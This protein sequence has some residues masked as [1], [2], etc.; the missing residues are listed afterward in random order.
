MGKKSRRQ[1]EAGGGARPHCLLSVR[2]GFFHAPTDQLVLRG[3]KEVLHYLTTEGFGESR[4]APADSLSGLCFVQPCTM[5]A[6]GETRVL[7]G[8]GDRATCGSTKNRLRLGEQIA[9]SAWGRALSIVRVLQPL[10][11]HYEWAAFTQQG[12]FSAIKRLL[13]E[14]VVYYCITHNRAPA[15]AQV[16]PRS[17]TMHMG[18]KEVFARLDLEMTRMKGKVSVVSPTLDA[19]RLDELQRERAAALSAEPAGW[20]ARPTEG[21]VAA[22]AAPPPPYDAIA[23]S[24]FPP[25]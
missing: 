13:A 12:S 8:A 22:A 5:T 24:G 18:A 2:N 17:A 20:E 6:H 9:W 3:R 7:A 14:D 10:E 25:E 23:P 21:F 16:A 19:G 15:H 1:R 11:T 4:A